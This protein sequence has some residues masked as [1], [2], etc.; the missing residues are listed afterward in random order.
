[1][2]PL[3]PSFNNKDYFS[4]QDRQ[5]LPSV[6]PPP[7]YREPTE[8]ANRRSDRSVIDQR[9]MGEK[10][11][12]LGPSHDIHGTANPAG[13]WQPGEFQRSYPKSDPRNAAWYKDHAWQSHDGRWVTKAGPPTPV[14]PNPVAKAAKVA[15]KKATGRR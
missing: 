12:P 2:A 14:K 8:R 11:W 3:M 13:E 15:A 7:V 9:Q 10:G 5:S 4:N 1:M 6:S